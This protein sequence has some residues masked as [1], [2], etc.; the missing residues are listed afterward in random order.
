MSTFFRKI[1]NS[2][3]DKKK[4]GQ[5]MVEF[6]LIL[7]IILMSLFVIIELARV[8]H[9]W[10]AIE[11]GARTAVRF[12]VTG[13]Y[14]PANCDGGFAGLDCTFLSDEPEARVESI[15]EAAWA[16][17]TSIIR[18]AEFEVTSI[19]PSFFKVT[20]C[21]P[22]T[23]VG[24]LST[25][26]ETSCPGGE[27]PG[28][29]GDRVTVVVEFN[30]PLFLPGLS[31]IWPQLRLTAMREATVETF[32]VLQSAGSPPTVVAPPIP[33]TST[34]PAT[35]T[36]LPQPDCENIVFK[37]W[38]W[39]ANSSGEY[40]R[41]Y[42]IW[43]DSNPED[44]FITEFTVEFPNLGG[45]YLHKMEFKPDA[46]NTDWSFNIMNGPHFS[47]PFFKSF[48]APNNFWLSPTNKSSRVSVN[49]GGL[50]GTLPGGSYKLKIR[51]EYP[52]FTTPCDKEAFSTPPGSPPPGGGGGGGGGGG[53]DAP[54]PEFPPTNTPP[55]G[56]P[57][58]TPGGVGD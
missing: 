55:S 12:A 32:R 53:T 27:D 28:G 19:D 7:P 34:P 22:I 50:S 1:A 20:I 26:G 16:G 41:F 38:K 30:H 40:Y 42:V 46:Q 33:N 10:L 57:T 4:I 58:A 56:G 24:P 11:N 51:V 18:V 36:P 31:S 25:F 49:F 5:G 13:E 17:S 29:P 47:S 43:K 8:L 23:M 9:A 35:I 2:A 3:K 21:D 37:T 54:T 45:G 14:N 44:G 48:G 6:A 39:K 52:G 15:H